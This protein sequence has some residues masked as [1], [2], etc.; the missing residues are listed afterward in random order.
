VEDLL[1]DTYVLLLDVRRL[2]TQRVVDSE[3]MPLERRREFVDGRLQ[4]IALR[5]EI[6]DRRLESLDRRF[7]VVE[8]RLDDVASSIEER[9]TEIARLL[10][11]R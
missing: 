9:T 6:V 2:L 3:V 7:D 4:T 5:V 11:R 1:R 8:R 10:R